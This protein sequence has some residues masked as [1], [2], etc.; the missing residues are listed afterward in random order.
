MALDENRLSRQ[1]LSRLLLSNASV[2]KESDFTLHVPTAIKIM[3][4]RLMLDPSL[5]EKRL[6]F[7][8]P[9]AF[10]IT[11]QSVDLDAASVGINATEPML[12]IRG[13]AFATVRV[14]TT[15]FHFV[16][17]KNALDDLL[18]DDGESYY[19]L[20]GTTIYLRGPSTVT[21]TL[22]IVANFI[23]SLANVPDEL[24]PL[25]LD[26]IVELAAGR[27]VDLKARADSGTTKISTA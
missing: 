16:A 12:I 20:E 27:A 4:Q 24:E 3:A 6:L 25:L 2:P 19:T 18:M 22:T 5:Y 8:K 7:Q 13:R 26:S 14:G 17:D 21:G 15:K 11:G 10:T 9:F 23:P 1:V